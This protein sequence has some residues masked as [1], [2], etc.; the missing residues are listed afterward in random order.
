MRKNINICNKV[1]KGHEF[2]KDMVQC[3]MEGLEEGRE[4]GYDV[5]IL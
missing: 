2:D 4:V 1:E 3:F 5:I